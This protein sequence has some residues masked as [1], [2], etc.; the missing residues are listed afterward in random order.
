M[1]FIFVRI[2]LVTLICKN[3][4]GTLRVNQGR[5]IDIEDAPYMARVSIKQSPTDGGACDGTILSDLYILTAG[6]CMDD[7]I[8]LNLYFLFFIYNVTLQV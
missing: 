4:F 7:F 3:G 5:P 6:H 8:E 1:S 2:L